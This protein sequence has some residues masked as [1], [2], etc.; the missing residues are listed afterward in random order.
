M[1]KQLYYTAFDCLEVANAF[2]R[3]RFTVEDVHRK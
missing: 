1:N 3:V 2:G